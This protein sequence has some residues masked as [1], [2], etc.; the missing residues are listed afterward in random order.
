MCAQQDPRMRF[1]LDRSRRINSS[2][3]RPSWGKRD[4]PN[5]RIKAVLL[6]SQPQQTPR[7]QQYSR[8]RGFTKRRLRRAY[9]CATVAFALRAM[10]NAVRTHL[11]SSRYILCCYTEQSW[12]DETLLWRAPSDH[13]GMNYRKALRAR[14]V[15]RVAGPERE[16]MELQELMT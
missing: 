5:P 12:L 15:W 11:K 3:P 4:Q 9:A 10:A 8:S 6:T 7:A 16:P 14:R 2:P 13:V 1:D